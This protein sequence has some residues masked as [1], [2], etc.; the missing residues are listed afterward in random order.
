[1]SLNF[2]NGMTT[3]EVLEVC[4]SYLA[5]VSSLTWI[6]REIFL[7]WKLLTE[8]LFLLNLTEMCNFL[9]TLPN[10]FQVWLSL[11]LLEKAEAF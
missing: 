2:V 1:M 7:T 11:V 3:C 6:L 4:L 5:S 9:Q 8:I 10:F